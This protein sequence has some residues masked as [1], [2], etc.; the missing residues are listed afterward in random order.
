MKT[1]D[2]NILEK[3]IPTSQMFLDGNYLLPI[4]NCISCRIIPNS[5]YYSIVCGFELNIFGSLLIYYDL[6]T[7]F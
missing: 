2:L 5:G 1:L 3:K 6:I 7:E 4:G